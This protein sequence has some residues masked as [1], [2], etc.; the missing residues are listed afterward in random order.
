MIQYIAHIYKY[1]RLIHYVERYVASITN[2]EPDIEGLAELIIHIKACG[3]VAIKFCQW[4][5]PKLESMFTSKEDPQPEWLTMLEEL[6]EDCDYHDEAYTIQQY[7]DLF[8]SAFHKDYEILDVIGSGS[9]GQVYLVQNKPL[10]TYSEPQ[11][12]VMKVRHPNVAA[13]IASFRSFYN[14][15]EYF[16]YVQTLLSENFPFDIRNFIDQFEEQSDFVSESNHLLHFKELYRDNTSII[17]PDLIRVGP[18]IMIMSYEKGMAFDSI[19]DSDSHH[20]YKAAV[21]L[22]S[23]MKNN[24]HILN[25]HHGDLHKG[26]WKVRMEDGNYKLIIYDFGFCWRVPEYKKGAIEKLREIFEETDDDVDELDLDE[27]VEIFRYF[28]K[29]DIKDEEHITNSIREYIEN[30]LDDIAPWAADPSRLFKTTVNICTT[31]KLHLDPLLI[32]VLIIM[33]QCQKIFIEFRMLGSD[34]E[35]ITSHEVFR[36]KYIDFITFFSTYGIFPE[37]REYLTDILNAHQTHISGIF[38]YIEMPDI[39]KQMAL[40]NK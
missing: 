39:I 34:T 38:D 23:F 36:S 10:T 14:I 2:G 7:E 28:I 13:E 30:H 3:S 22:A 6:Y 35:I 4:S 15:I 8:K 17:V 27:F 18:S 26:N 20:K 9:I 25:Y 5:I 24:Q 33:I 40:K 11:K 32:Q 29:Y 21:L 19:P 1:V 12:Y 16:P 31:L 37:L